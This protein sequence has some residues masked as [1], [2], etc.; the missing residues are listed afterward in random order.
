MSSHEQPK[1]ADP[2]EDTLPVLVQRNLQLE[3]GEAWTLLFI[4]N[5]LHVA[6][7]SSLCQGNIFFFP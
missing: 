5:F 3:D 4:S 2:T 6:A 7:G 1:L